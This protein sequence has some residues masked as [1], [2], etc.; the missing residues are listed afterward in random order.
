MKHTEGKRNL[1]DLF[2]KE[3][4]DVSHFLDIQKMIL[5]STCEVKLGLY[6]EYLH[7]N[8][9]VGWSLGPVGQVE[10]VSNWGI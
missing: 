1:S 8:T 9:S 2:P 6:Q 5:H 4:K 10:G 3:D 7:L